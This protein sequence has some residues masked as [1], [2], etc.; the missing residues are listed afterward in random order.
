VLLDLETGDRTDIESDGG[1]RYG[2]IAT[3]GSRAFYTNASDSALYAIDVASGEIDWV[4]EDDITLQGLVASTGNAAV[5]T[6]NREFR[7]FDPETGDVVGQ[8]TAAPELVVA[9]VAGD[10]VTYA[11]GGSVAAHEVDVN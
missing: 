1:W 3:T 2:N 8:G 11:C 9:C 10:D 6:N 7:A 5:S 4:A